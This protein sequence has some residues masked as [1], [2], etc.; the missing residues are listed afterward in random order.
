[1]DLINLFC[2]IRIGLQTL[3]FFG[4]MSIFIQCSFGKESENKFNH[5]MED[6]H[7]EIIY[8]K[9]PEK[10]FFLAEEIK[11]KVLNNLK[12]SDNQPTQLQELVSID[13]L[14]NAILKKKPHGVY[15]TYY[16]TK[17]NL[18]TFVINKSRFY[19]QKTTINI[20]SINNALLI[21]EQISNHPPD[22]I[23]GLKQLNEYKKA[24]EYLYTKLLE[25]IEPWIN[26]FEITFNPDGILYFLDFEQISLPAHLAD[27]FNGLTTEKLNKTD[28]I[29]PEIIINE[30]W[31][32]IHFLIEDYTVN[33]STSIQYWLTSLHKKP[34][35][36]QCISADPKIISR[37]LLPI[38]EQHDYIIDTV[39]NETTSDQ[40]H[41][42]IHECRWHFT[43]FQSVDTEMNYSANAV[44]FFN[45][46]K[47]ESKENLFLYCHNIQSKGTKII[48]SQ[49]SKSPIKKSIFFGWAKYLQ[50]FNDANYSLRTA[51]G[52]QINNPE[53]AHPYY[54]N[55]WKIWGE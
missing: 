9:S 15:V 47:P 26:G 36:N 40:I 2:I 49:T 53:T 14:R 3:L 54:W 24:S 48:F 27:P 38:F 50:D 18:Y 10:A 17:T 22:Y 1:M 7:Y 51:I 19:S 25:P 39:P 28:R 37:N 16:L 5:S 20:D 6:E 13:S 31:K 11:L 33:Y 4:I 43:D 41:G 32:R 12:K 42:Q 46:Q 8:G 55:L 30:S 23:H 45:L 44:F 29:P 21:F 52:D 35:H 34:I